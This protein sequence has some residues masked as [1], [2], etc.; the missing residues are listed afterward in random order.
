MYYD[1]WGYVDVPKNLGVPRIPQISQ[2]NRTMMNRQMDEGSP[3]VEDGVQM[4]VISEG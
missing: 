2:R 3:L 4:A 1:N